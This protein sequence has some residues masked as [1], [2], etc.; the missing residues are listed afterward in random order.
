MKYMDPA[1]EV[2]NVSAED[3][4]TTSNGSGFE[5]PVAPL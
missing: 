4:I 2:V 3:V 5:T 1:M